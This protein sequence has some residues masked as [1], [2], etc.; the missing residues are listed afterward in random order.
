MSFLRAASRGLLGIALF[1]A[2]PASA[3]S[4]SFGLDFEFSGGTQPEGATPWATITID[5]AA[6]T[7]G[8]NSVRVTISNNLTDGEFISEFSLNLDPAL[9]PTQLTFTAVNMNAV[10]NPAGDPNDFSFSTGVDAF[11]ADGDGKFDMRLGLPPPPGAFAAKY[12]AGETLV[13]DLTFSAA[14]SAADF[15]FGSASGGGNGT[16]RAAAHV[17]GIGLDDEDSGWIGPVP[18]PSVALLMAAGALAAGIA[19]R[20]QR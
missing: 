4:I 10:G 20:K 12:T 14:L 9:D 18:E 13:F 16:F 7:G 8:A 3:L 11:Q 2:G 5:D 1:G 17:Q 15:D 6:D 19:I